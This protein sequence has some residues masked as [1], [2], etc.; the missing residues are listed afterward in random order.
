MNIRQTYVAV[1]LAV[2]PAAL[3]AQDSP[4]PA[5]PP[6]EAAASASDQP[7]GAGVT[8]QKGKETL[9]VDFPNAEIRTILRNIADLFDLNLVIPETLEGRA[10]LK[11][12]DVTWRQIFDV[13]LQPVGYTYVTDGNIIKVVSIESLNVEPVATNVYILNYARAADIAPTVNSMIDASKG[14]KLQ[15]ERSR[16]AAMRSSSRSARSAMSRSAR[17]SPTSIAPPIR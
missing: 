7:E 2:L 3:L 8:G 17:L 16:R 4:A 14:G 11:L 5:T 15:V 12:R 9:S 13:L 10:S 1:A 6:V